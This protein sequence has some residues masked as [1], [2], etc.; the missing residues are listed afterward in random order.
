[1]GKLLDSGQKLHPRVGVVVTTWSHE[2]GADYARGLVDLFSQTAAGAEV[3]VVSCPRLLES[4]GDIA[5]IQSYLADQQLDAVCLICGNFTLDH[6]MPLLAQAIRLPALLWAL[7]GREAWGALVA[8]QQTLFPFKELGLP[9]KFVTGRLGDARVWAR[10]LPFLRACAIVRRLQGLRLGV[11]GWRAEGMS[12]VVFDEIA[13]RKTFGVQLV[14][15]GLT[16]YT[17]TLQE[18]PEDEV[19]VAWR[20]ISPSF[21]TTQ[22]PEKVGRYGARSYLALKRLTAEENLQAVTLECFHDHLGGPCMG[23]C[24]M[25]DQGIPAPCENDVHA[26]ILMAAGQLLSGEP[27]FHADIVEAD[28]DRNTAVMH[29]CGN[30][31]LRLASTEPKPALKPIRET[32]GP[33]AFGPTI[34]AWMKAGPVTAINLVGGALGLR[35]AALEG[36]ILAEK[37]DLPGS[38]ALMAFP[39]DLAASLEKMGNAG[40]G[41]HF[42][43]V[44]GHL[45]VEL[46]EWCALSGVAYLQPEVSPH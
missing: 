4:E 41:H 38:G 28:Y 36:E 25:N 18:I 44:P 12:D 42:V 39:Y 13:L 29:H 43:I 21:D 10:A 7:P 16:R 34:Q 40:Y 27:T 8:I 2:S 6:V 23:F 37:V 26:A 46:A 11:M 30:L 20:E 14:N 9:Y 1:M 22:L 24:L 32:V 45:G 19:E 15:L 17:R 3:Q 35:V 5:P 31:P 33:G